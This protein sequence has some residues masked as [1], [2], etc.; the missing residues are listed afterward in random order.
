MK[1]IILK[2]FCIFLFLIF[3]CK[4]KEF[5]VIHEPDKP[6]YGEEVKLKF[7]Q[8][9]TGYIYIF[10]LSEGDPYRLIPSV[11]KIKGIEEL[12]I[13]PKD[14]NTS[15]ILFAFENEKG[16]LIIDSTYYIIFYTKEGKPLPFALSILAY[17]Y[18]SKNQAFE[19]YEKFSFLWEKEREYYKEHYDFM[20]NKFYFEIKKGIKKTEEV[21]KEIKEN[22][23]KERGNSS[24]LHAAYL[25]AHWVL[26]DSIFA[27]EILKYFENL[28]DDKYKIDVYIHHLKNFEEKISYI[29]DK[30]VDFFIK[31]F[32]HYYIHKFIYPSP[33]IDEF[34]KYLKEREKEGF[35]WTEEL[36]NFS[37]RLFKEKEK[38]IFLKMCEKIIENPLKVRQDFAFSKFPFF[39]FNLEIYKIWDGEKMLKKE[40]E[41]IYFDISNFYFSNNNFDSS[42]FYIKKIVEGEK[43]EDIDVS[44][45]DLF[46]RCAKKINKKEEAIISYAYLVYYHGN[47]FYEDTLKNIGKNY[48]KRLEK[49]KKEIFSKLKVPDFEVD[50]IDGSKFKYSENKN[51][52]IVLNFWFTRCGPCKAEISELNKTFEKFKD[53][54]D[55]IFLAIS[56][57]D[58]KTVEDFLKKQEFLYK[59]GIN[60]ATAIRKF[61]VVAYPLHIIIDKK[62]K[63]AYKHLG[64]IACEELE[65]KIKKL[66][67][68]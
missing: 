32:R 20:D 62:G 61:K 7:S 37:G 18:F 24:F 31:D 28:K 39:P 38:K 14:K 3:S 21:K 23:E 35:V 27:E 42:Y 2:V 11:K 59:I 9:F 25:T 51:K 52:I 26:E 49:I 43:L 15:L 36:L 58:K 46:A 19:N 22:L 50:L 17:I 57:E 12:K 30:D 13:K 33:Q 1:K 6:I 5:K 68:K 63:I 54:K 47:H 48:E 53:N 66:M 60:G 34:M 44:T 4:K 64:P 8:K 55:V 56:F 16:K 45:L 67:M 10:E 65:Q 41:N 29:K 40:F